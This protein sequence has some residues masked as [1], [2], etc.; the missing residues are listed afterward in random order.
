MAAADSGL[1]RK[2]SGLKALVKTGGTPREDP[3]DQLHRIPALADGDVDAAEQGALN[4]HLEDELPS[5][6]ACSPK[7]GIEIE[8]GG[9]GKTQRARALAAFEWRRLCFDGQWVVVPSLLPHEVKYIDVAIRDAIA[10]YGKKVDEPDSAFGTAKFPIVDPAGAGDPAVAA[11]HQRGAHLAAFAWRRLFCATKW[12]L[13]P[14]LSKA[15]VQLIGDEIT[16]KFKSSGATPAGGLGSATAEVAAM[17]DDTG[18]L[19]QLIEACD[20]HTFNKEA[21]IKTVALCIVVEAEV[22]PILQAYP[23][24]EDEALNKAF[25]SLAYVR[26][27]DMGS[28]RLSVIKAAESPIFHRHY[29]GYTQAAAMAALV[30]SVMKPELTISFGTAGGVPGR[31]KIGDTVLTDACLYMDR[32]RTRNKNAF[33]WGV[34][35]GGCARCDSM[36]KELGLVRGTVASQI[37][38]AVT[39][40]QERLIDKV[41]IAC[42]DMEAASIAEVMNQTGNNMIA[43]K[44]I[45]NG[46]YPGEPRKMEAEYHD[47]REEVSRRATESL[48]RVLEFLK[49]KRICDL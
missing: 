17:I 20:D 47:Y 16:A 21:P 5:S 49:D 25:M 34:W 48:G 31:A 32:L 3:I 37:G 7:L 41:G 35:G 42:L 15:E 23:F 4:Q 46:V 27:A 38:Y 33:D 2:G 18:R 30:S 24:E 45:S 26:S 22:R 9:S 36:A 39:E 6:F 13:V 1:D 12:V 28:Y 19:R 11:E 44:V 40:M 29:S 43:L 8:D 10:K 14:S